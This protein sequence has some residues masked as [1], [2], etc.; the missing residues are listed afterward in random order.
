MNRI[1]ER[2]SKTVVNNINIRIFFNIYNIK[3]ISKIISKN[4][5]SN[6]QL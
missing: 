1:S 5:K 2:V 6:I 3:I 4:A